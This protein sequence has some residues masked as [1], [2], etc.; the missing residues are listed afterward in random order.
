M[1]FIERARVNTDNAVRG[2]RQYPAFLYL[3]YQR[4]LRV[5]GGIE[6]VGPYDATNYYRTPAQRKLF[7]CEPEEPDQERACAERIAANLA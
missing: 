2:G 3:G 5:V 4:L 1:T 7:I 6:V